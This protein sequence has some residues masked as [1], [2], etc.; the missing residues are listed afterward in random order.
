MIKT[1]LGRNIFVIYWGLIVC[2]LVFI[3]WFSSRGGS[4]SSL[5]SRRFFDFLLSHF[6]PP[7]MKLGT[8][9]QNTFIAEHMFLFRKLAHFAEFTILGFL[10]YPAFSFIKTKAQQ[11]AFSILFCYLI[12]CFDELHQAFVPGRSPKITDTAIDLFGS[13]MGIIAF[14]IILKIIGAFKKRF[15]LFSILLLFVT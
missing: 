7:Y 3:F 10:T 14:I 8:V 4:S 1:K 2:W 11:A 5:D 6:Y 9:Q 12:A 13:I 15:S